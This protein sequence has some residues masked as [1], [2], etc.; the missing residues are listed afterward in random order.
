M[1]FSLAQ[2]I[3][4][5]LT[6]SFGEMFIASNVIVMRIDG[7]AMMPNFSFG[8][9]M[10]TYSGQ[11]VGAGDKERVLRGTKQG[12]MI[13]VGVS[14]VLT[15]I[16]LFF[17]RYLMMLFTDTEDLIQLSVHNIHI[18][19][20][21]YLAVAVTQ[22][23]QGTMRGAGDTV[24]PMWISLVSTV[25]IRV[26]LA[27]SIRYFTTTPELPT[28][29]SDCI[30]ISLMSSWVIAMILTLIFYMKGR[31]RRK[32]DD[33]VFPEMPDMEVSETE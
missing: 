5:S 22:C 26:P 31:W 8:A 6:N 23:L 20:V 21:G 4:Q 19:A 27:Y 32:L 12:T 9:A 18:L 28:G 3:V 2:V 14:A 17:G 11:N 10:T 1:V 7:F 15:S 30:F 25:A 33:L 16:M 29:S 13:A 24:T